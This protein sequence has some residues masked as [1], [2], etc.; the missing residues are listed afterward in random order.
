MNLSEAKDVLLRTHL[1]ALERGERASGYVMESP[2]GVG[3]SQ[4]SMQYAENLAKAL[5]EPVAITIFM[6]TT[7]TSPDVRGFMLPLK[8][9]PGEPLQTVFSIPPWYPSLDN[10]HVVTPDGTWFKPGEYEDTLPVVGILC[11]DEW[12]QADEDV[13]KPAAELIL[14]GNVGTTYLPIGYRVIAAQNRMSDRSGTVRE[15]MFIVNRRCLL[16]IDP[17][18]PTW[19]AHINTLPEA[20]RPHFLTESFARKN[21]DIVFRTTVPDGTDPF[22]TPRSLCLMDRDLQALAS[23]EDR[24]H[25]RLPMTGVAR[26]VCAGWIG[27]AAAGHYYTHLRFA[28]E[29]PDMDDIESEPSRAKLPVG[30][31]AQMV[32]AY[33]MAH[34]ITDE[35]ARNILRYILRMEQEMQ[36]LAVS[37]I[38]ADEKRRKIMVPVRE[39]QT[40]LM[41][42]KDVLIA[43]QS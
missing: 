4:A 33:M 16:P 5:G 20:Q 26:E 13:K 21:P 42:N 28:D 39:Y 19:L 1:A 43:S 15:M 12:G 31:D 29:L 7:I 24:A 11:L 18:L 32:C 27:A 38:G 17:S 3:K 37:V 8:P 36:I 6:M 10:S 41:Q 35:N 2:P 14:N 34:H 40:W 23:D 9:A 22:C 30:R 25:H